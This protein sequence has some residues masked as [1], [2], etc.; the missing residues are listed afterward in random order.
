ML[1]KCLQYYGLYS[2][3]PI[4]RSLQILAKRTSAIYPNGYQS[5]PKHTISC[6]HY[7]LAELFNI[8]YSLYHHQI[9]NEI[10]RYGALFGLVIDLCVYP[11][12]IEWCYNPMHKR[13]LFFSELKLS[14][15]STKTYIA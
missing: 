1:D 6:T 3:I 14:N 7:E 10:F 9:I 8:K 5:F 4:A 12:H 11:T 15:R 13:D 2:Y